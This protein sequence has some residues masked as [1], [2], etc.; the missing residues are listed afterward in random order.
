MIEAHREMHAIYAMKVKA[1]WVLGRMMSGVKR[2]KEADCKNAWIIAET[3]PQEIPPIFEYVQ[4]TTFVSQ[5]L[6][7]V[8]T[9]VFFVAHWISVRLYVCLEKISDWMS[10]NSQDAYVD[11]TVEEWWASYFSTTSIENTEIL[12][13]VYENRIWLDERRK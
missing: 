2:E 13:A 1:A 8:R 4:F 11:I 5:E 9:P 12:F 7:H 10:P 6:G 3:Q